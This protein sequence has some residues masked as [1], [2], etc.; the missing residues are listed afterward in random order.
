MI[1][2]LGSSTGSAAAYLLQFLQQA[3]GTDAADGD[4]ASLAQQL[5]QNLDEDSGGAVSRNE[6]SSFTSRF[7][8]ETGAALMS[9]QESSSDD[10]FSQF[11]SDSDG[12]VSLDELAAALQPPPDETASSAS[13]AASGG[14]TSES[15]DPLDINKDGVVSLEERMAAGGQHS[16]PTT[17]NLS[18]GTLG[19]LFQSIGQIAA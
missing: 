3:S 19:N 12:S 6:F 2:S 17:G 14:S 15:Y 8:P 11:D 4:S 1:S 18:S 9:A 16:T 10:L 7:A 5:F 13:S